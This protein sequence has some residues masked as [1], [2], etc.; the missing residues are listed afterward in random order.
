[1]ANLR[2]FGKTIFLS[3]LLGGAVAGAGQANDQPEPE[4]AACPQ[5]TGTI[6]WVNIY[7][8]QG[9]V[10]V[11]HEPVVVRVN[12]CEQ[13]VWT[14]D[15]NKIREITV[16]TQWKSKADPRA[17]DPVS[18]QPTPSQG[19]ANPFPRAFTGTPVPA[20]F[21]ATSS[22]GTLAS[23]QA[24]SATVGHVYKFIIT[25]TEVGGSTLKSKDPHTRFD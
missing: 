21:S 22:T 23:K 4:S 18:Y 15:K 11:D 10:K 1:M 9:T 3:L 19:P 2:S 17:I 8:D 13:I 5:P 14:F 24:N 20:V 6:Q 12:E 7:V 16:S 25:V